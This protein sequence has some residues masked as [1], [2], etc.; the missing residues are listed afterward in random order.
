MNK[1]ELYTKDDDV[2]VY[3]KKTDGYYDIERGLKRFPLDMF[4]DFKPL[5]TPI[6]ESYRDQP[7][8]FGEE[9][10][11][12]DD[13]DFTKKIYPKTKLFASYG[14]GDTSPFKCDKGTAFKY[15]RKIET[16]TIHGL[17][18]CP[19]VISRHRA[20]SERDS[21]LKRLKYYNEALG[22]E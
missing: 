20:I 5:V 1:Y 12:S 14:I 3:E 13:E 8:K 10:E 21:M 22:D 18:P 11:V 2:E 17:G 19:T 7:F 4:D 16:I 6:M 9:I 15:A